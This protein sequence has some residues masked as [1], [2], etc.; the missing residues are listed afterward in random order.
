MP[1]PTGTAVL[2]TAFA[3]GVSAL[4]AAATGLHAQV[5]PTQQPAPPTEAR[6]ATAPPVQGTSS[7]GRF[8]RI[9]D[10]VTREVDSLVMFRGRIPAAL[11][12]GKSASGVLTL[13]ANCGEKAEKVPAKETTGASG[14]KKEAAE[15]AAAGGD[16]LL[17]DLK[18]MYDL[19]LE[20]GAFIFFNDDGYDAD[21][22][23]YAA[24]P[25]AGPDTGLTRMGSLLFLSN[26]SRAPGCP[27][28]VA[29]RSWGTTY[30]APIAECGEAP[31]KATE[32][33]A[34]PEGLREL[35]RDH[36][37]KTTEWAG[38]YKVAF[39]YRDGA[40]EGPLTSALAVLAAGKEDFLAVLDLRKL[41]SPQS[42]YFWMTRRPHLS[43]RLDQNTVTVEGSGEGAAAYEP[44][45]FVE[46]P[47]L[48]VLGSYAKVRLSPAAGGP[49]TVLT[50]GFCDEC[51]PS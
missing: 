24:Y 3:A 50:L 39:R 43:V 29:L 14:S 44:D 41:E 15:T 7:D 2:R 4:F 5:P 6:P 19:R 48:V 32:A 45:T 1:R 51:P 28:K 21:G 18:G 17:L 9:L 16:L 42:S 26:V 46:Y 12:V 36:M 25:T 49:E 23:E 30:L 22:R 33:D 10:R 34:G 40:A 37:T 31:A 27:F 38:R 11:S 8:F 47:Y 35:T 20:D 13:C